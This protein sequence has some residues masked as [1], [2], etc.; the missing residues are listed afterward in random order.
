M[1]FN[2]ANPFWHSLEITAQTEIL[3]YSNV[4]RLPDVYKQVK[5]NNIHY[6]S[7][8]ECVILWL[9]SLSCVGDYFNRSRRK[10]TVLT[11]SFTCD[12]PLNRIKHTPKLCWGPCHPYFLND[13]KLIKQ[14]LKE[15]I[16]IHSPD[17]S[18]NLFHCSISQ[19]T[20]H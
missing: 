11:N 18:C 12:N 10:S 1:K 4:N 16:N 3:G 19:Y 8:D 20:C 6:R 13:I 17:S 9:V 2:Y 7:D 14:L 5:S 15:K